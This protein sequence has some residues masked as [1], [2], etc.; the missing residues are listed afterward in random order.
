MC[1][2]VAGSVFLE[3]AAN[4]FKIKLFQVFFQLFCISKINLLLFIKFSV[5]NLCNWWEN[6]N[7]V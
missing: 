2:S 1:L 3:Y 6:G 5:F 7:K 4:S